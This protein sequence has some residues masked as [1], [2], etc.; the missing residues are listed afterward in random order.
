ML[1]L[2]F[3]LYIIT[4][5]KSKVQM[6]SCI[7]FVNPFLNGFVKTKKSI[8]QVEKLLVTTEKYGIIFYCM[9]RICIAK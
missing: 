9:L 2:Q 3:L 6:Y 5:Q 1:I 4:I 8:N 7:N